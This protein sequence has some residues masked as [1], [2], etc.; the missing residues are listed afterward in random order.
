MR[1][2]GPGL[3]VRV[4][5]RV[6]CGGLGWAGLCCAVRGGHLAVRVAAHLAAGWCEAWQEL[7]GGD[8]GV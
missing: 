4:R 8:P 1:K 6:L 3:L 5:S 2:G 7:C